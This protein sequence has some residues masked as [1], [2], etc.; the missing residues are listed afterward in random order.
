MTRPKKIYACYLVALGLL[1]PVL[2]QAQSAANHALNPLGATGGA[3]ELAGRVIRLLLGFTGVASLV[4]FIWGGI[5]LLTSRGNQDKIK[6]GRD[7][8]VWAVIGMFVAF[9][10]YIILRY[11]IQAVVT[12]T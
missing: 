4:F 1:L 6:S 5:E 7:T 10:S 9:S 8:I 3:P 12:R 11:V 2:A